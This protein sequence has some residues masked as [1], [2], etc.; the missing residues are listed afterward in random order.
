MP[1]LKINEMTQKLFWNT[2]SK[3]Y[4][5]ALIST[6]VFREKLESQSF[7]F[8]KV[9]RYFAEDKIFFMFSLWSL[10]CTMMFIFL[11]TY[12][13][14]RRA[15]GYP[16]P[17]G[18]KLEKSPLRYQIRRWLWSEN[19]TVWYQ[20]NRNLIYIIYSIHHV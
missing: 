12:F 10:W 6:K 14:I 3:I 9:F 7:R 1:V 4:L 13:D 2:V 5:V 18:P 17:T 19:F 15:L 16:D 11:G 8:S 20:I